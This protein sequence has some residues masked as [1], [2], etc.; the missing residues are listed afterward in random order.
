M[1]TSNH[2]LL[3]LE[4]HDFDV[5]ARQMRPMAFKAGEILYEPEDQVDWIYFP[6]QGLISLLSVMLSGTAVETAVVGNEGGVGF[7]EVAGAGVTFSRAL[8]Q[9][10]LLALRVSAEAYNAAFDASPSLRKRVTSHVELLLAEARQTLACQSHHSHEQRLAWWL[11]ECQDRTGGGP[12]LPLK[13]DFLAA[14]LGVQRSTVSQVAGALKAD[15]LI[16]YTRGEIQILD[17]QRL[18]RRSCECYATAA[19]YRNLIEAR[20]QA[21][22]A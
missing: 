4:A 18:E 12:R 19:H 5:L 13:Q 2:L 9:V 11:L 17:R 8:V 16:D 6:E 10:D 20:Q 14:M 3:S 22:S 21:A 7:L 15:G 1:Q